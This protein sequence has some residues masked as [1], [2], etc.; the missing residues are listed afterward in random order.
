M[1]ALSS[2]VYQLPQQEIP[3]A[4]EYYSSMCSI[5][6]KTRDFQRSVMRV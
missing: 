1:S 6:S 5:A 3:S 2:R 4:F